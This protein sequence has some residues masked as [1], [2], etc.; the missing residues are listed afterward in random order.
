MLSD[1]YGCRAGLPTLPVAADGSL[2]LRP[3]RS[4]FG[5]ARVIE[6]D[7]DKR[8]TRS[9]CKLSAMVPDGSVSL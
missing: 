2:K 9:F 5:S 7:A 8:S 6:R 1:R 3:G 4:A